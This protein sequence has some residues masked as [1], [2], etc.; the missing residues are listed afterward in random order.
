VLKPNP[1]KAGRSK[2]EITPLFYLKRETKQVRLKIFI[3]TTNRLLGNINNEYRIM[4]I[5]CRRVESLSADFAWA[6]LAKSAFFSF[7]MKKMI[8]YLSSEILQ[9]ISLGHYFDIR[10]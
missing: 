10:Y 7:Y 5:E 4:N 2:T 8:K 1:D 3:R 6:T 9:S